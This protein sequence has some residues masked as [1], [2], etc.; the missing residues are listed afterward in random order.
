MPK[1]LIVDDDPMFL[2]VTKK[3]LERKDYLVEVAEGGEEAIAQ[4]YIF[5]P[6]VVI[7][8]V[9]MPRMTGQ[10]IIKIIKAWKPELQVIMVSSL[11]T[12]GENPTE[13][14]A[15]AF[16][17]KPIEFE[18]LYKTVEDALNSGKNPEKD[19]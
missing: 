15:F 1:I 10:E 18:T 5:D 13:I 17:Q 6:A 7:L 8:D 14:G 11:K 12:M 16:L 3:I 19:Q 9:L 2:K 4:I